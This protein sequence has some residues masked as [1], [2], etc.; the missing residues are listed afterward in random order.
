MSESNRLLVAAVEV[1]AFCVRVKWKFCF[2]GGIAVQ[3]WG[4]ARL[5][6]DAD[7]TVF[8]GIGDE[9]RYVDALLAAFAPRIEGMREFSLRNRVLLLQASN[10]IPV[11][12][13]LGALDF[14]QLAVDRS[15]LV[16]IIAAFASFHTTSR[17]EFAGEKQFVSDPF[18]FGAIVTLVVL[19]FPLMP[20]GDKIYSAGSPIVKNPEISQ[21][22]LPRLQAPGR[23]QRSKT[24]EP[25]LLG[26]THGQAQLHRSADIG[27]LGQHRL[28]ICLDR[29]NQ[30]QRL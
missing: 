24:L 30:A 18:G 20:Y 2:I 13:S 6:R 23:C 7:L 8:T 15:L 29:F 1:Q 11:D 25:V 26:F 19:G 12:V 9:P 28:K 14:E 5:T 16:E 22:P 4:E 17:H 21:Q 27:M 3:H 10:G